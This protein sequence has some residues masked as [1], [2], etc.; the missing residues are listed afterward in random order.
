MKLNGKHQL[1]V[2]ADAVN[3]WSEVYILLKKY[4]NLVVA[5]KEMG[6]EVNANGTKNVVMY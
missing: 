5:S 4:R 1:L 3:I 6:L 2:Y